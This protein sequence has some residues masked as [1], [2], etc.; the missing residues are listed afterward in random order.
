MLEFEQ[1]D[2]LVKCISLVVRWLPFFFHKSRSW[3]AFQTH[4]YRMSAMRLGGLQKLRCCMVGED[5]APENA[6][7]RYHSLFI[8]KQFQSPLGHLW[9]ILPP[10]ICYNLSLIKWESPQFDIH[11]YI[12]QC[13]ISIDHKLHEVCMY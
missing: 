6:F 9:P 1:F 7:M 11:K 5:L 2:A 3:E 8:R 10:R 4:S 12:T 13:I